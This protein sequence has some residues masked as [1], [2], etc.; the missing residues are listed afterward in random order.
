MQHQRMHAKHTLCIRHTYLGPTCKKHQP[1]ASDLQELPCWPTSKAANGI[2][3]FVNKR[4]SSSVGHLSVT[5]ATPSKLPLSHLL[6]LN[7]GCDPG[8]CEFFLYLC[9]RY[10]VVLCD[11]VSRFFNKLYNQN[12]R[13]VLETERPFYSALIAPRFELAGKHASDAPLHR[14]PFR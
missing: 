13:G 12:Q 1:R 2:R 5:P 11:V 7:I 4:L 3:L 14:C 9:N 6:T 8:D 10:R